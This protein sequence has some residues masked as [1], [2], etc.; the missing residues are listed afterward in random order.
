MTDAP[1]IEEKKKTPGSMSP[2]R[3]ALFMA[4]ALTLIFIGLNLLVGVIGRGARIDLTDDR[5]YSLSA[6]TNKIVRG[7]AEPIDLT[8]YYSADAS[9]SNPMLRAY[10]ARV[11]ELLQ[12]YAARSRGKV[13]IHEVNPVRFT[14]AED[15]AVALGIEPV[16]YQQGGEPVYFGLVG[17]NAADERIFVP[18][19]AAEREPYLEY[20]ITRMIAELEAPRKLKLA[21]ITSLPVDPFSLS[22]TDLAASQPAFFG[23]LARLGALQVLDRGFTDIPADADEVI[24]IQP[25]PLSPQQLYALDQFILAKGRAFIAVDPAAMAW[26][27]PSEF[28]PSM[29]A[30]SATLPELLGKWGVTVSQDV[31]IDGRGALDVQTQDGAGREIVAPQPLYIGVPAAQLSKEDL[32]TAGLNRAINIAAPGAIS[33][34]PAD[35]VIVTPL[36]R[37]SGA[38]ARIPPEQALMGASPMEL[39][40]LVMD[41]PSNR[42]ETFAARIAGTLPS[43]FGAAPPAEVL[44]G[45]TQKHLAKSARPAEIVLVSDVDFLNDGFYMGQNRAPFAD[46]AAFALNAIDI[47]AG[48]DDLVSLRSRAPSLRPLTMLED[49]H[50]NAQERLRATEEKLR[51]ELQETEARLAELQSKGKG[52]GFFAGDLGAELTGEERDEVEKF[53]AE[54]MRVRADLRKVERSYRSDVDAL[55]GWL[56][57]INVWAA[58]ML[59][60]V[61]GLVLFWRRQRR[62]AGGRR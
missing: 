34:S 36:A 21:L 61:A 26:L 31:V 60:A 49:M 5:L 35:G 54:A 7:L 24:V 15:E 42:V 1:A 58:P 2:R 19:L 10:S 47:L 17:A 52:S 11:R 62:G 53:R 59:I 56:I 39:L 40:P 23:E 41:Q 55:Q 57:L 50:R 33:W 38:T 8:L 37:S 13:R 4:A 28:M 3:Y 18:H 20:E 45:R 29:T 30:P 12:T 46:N 43:A 14:E 48:S 25:W 32:V 51:A 22:Q 16:T 44:S 9:A 6:G 27:S